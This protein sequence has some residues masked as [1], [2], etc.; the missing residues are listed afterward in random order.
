MLTGSSLLHCSVHSGGIVLYGNSTTTNYGVFCIVKNVSIT[1]VV[2]EHV[3]CFVVIFQ[4]CMMFE[5]A[6][7]PNLQ[8]ER[9]ARQFKYVGLHLVMK[10]HACHGPMIVLAGR[11]PL[12]A[13]RQP[14][15]EEFKLMLLCSSTLPSYTVV[16]LQPIYTIAKTIQ[17]LKMQKRYSIFTT[18]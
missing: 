15:Q 3:L 10:A 7:F 1:D 16:S 5:R 12:I 14:H 13:G 18:D 2:V 11:Q 17:D 4:P 9:V 6:D 8:R